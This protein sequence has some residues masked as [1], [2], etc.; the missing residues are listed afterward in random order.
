[1]SVI[2]VLFVSI[3]AIQASDVNITD[4]TQLI[5]NE[6]DSI[7]LEDESPVS[8]LESDDSN[9]LSSASSDSSLSDP[10]KDKTEFASPSTSIYYKGSYGI[11]LKDSNKSAALANK[12]VNLVIDNVNYVAVTDNDGR[13]IVNLNLYPGK[14]TV[15]AFFSGDDAYESSNLFSTVEILP[16]IRAADM[17]KYYKGSTQFVAAFLDSQG[18]A[19]ANR[20]V[21]ISVGGNAYSVMTNG[22]GIASLPVNLKPGSYTIVSTDPD[23][24]YQ[25]TTT[26][27]V[28]STIS[29]SSVKMV[30]G[31]NKKFKVKFFKS[32]GKALSKKYVKYKFRGKV[33]KVKTSSKGY[34]TLSLKKLKKGTYKIVCYNKDG[35]SKTYK[36]KVYKKKASTK[37]SADSSTF[38]PDDKERIFKVKLSTALGGSSNSAKTVK[39]KIN[40]KTYSKKTDSSGMVYLDLSSFKSGIYNVECKYAGNKFFK[41]SKSTKTVKIY[42][43]TQTELKVKSTTHFGYGAGTLF[44]VAYTAGGVPLPGKTVTLSVNGDTYTRTTNDKGIASIPINLAIGTYTV[45]YSADG[46]STFDDASGSSPID[47]FERSQSKVIWKCGSSYKD[48][49]QTF[50]IL[51]TGMNGDAASGGSFD[52]VIDSDTYSS[53]LSSDGHG[54]VKTSIPIGNYKVVANFKGNNNYL[55]SSNS[56]SINVKLSKFANGINERNAKGSSAYLKSSSHCKVGSKGIKKL[57]KSLTKGLTSKVDKAKAIYN[58]VRDTLGYSYYFNT[59]YGAAKTLKYKKGNCADHSHLLVSMYRT[60]GFNARYVHGKCHFSDG[61][62]CGHVWVQVKVGK[63]WVVAD[64]TSSRNEIGKINNWNTKNYHLHNKYASLP[65]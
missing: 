63:K 47:V 7:H 23:T 64:A 4:S 62:Y 44:E 8:D 31:Q 18:N 61:D 21:T 59:K 12:N 27:T 60:A 38:Y 39:V 29:S 15:S 50:K 13:A 25:L 28:L 48:N 17:S 24:G 33:H 35:L 6:D 49:S 57:V 30:Q 37:L 34:I 45:D 53:E 5:S 36:I 1:M 3:S 32:N 9:N 42:D 19:M 41:S 2:F 43:T 26:F 16:T 14:Y 56:K 55:P 65:F 20:M 52:I 58:Y 40:G 22:E 54:K 51:V 46:D 11:T 10:P